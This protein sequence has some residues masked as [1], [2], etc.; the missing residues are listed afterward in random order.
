VSDSQ[1]AENT[2]DYRKMLH[3]PEYFM[4]YCLTDYR[5]R[6]DNDLCLA[7]FPVRNANFIQIEQQF[8]QKPLDV[9]ISIMDC[10]LEE[11]SGYLQTLPF[12]R[13]SFR[14]DNW[15]GRT[16]NKRIHHAA[17]EWKFQVAGE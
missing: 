9:F 7:S 14:V 6:D 2:G 1:A 15:V 11:H 10:S 8:N 3:C 17:R 12:L 16:K 5:S 13:D 4:M